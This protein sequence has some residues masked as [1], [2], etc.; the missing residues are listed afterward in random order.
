MPLRYQPRVVTSRDS[1]VVAIAA[2]GADLTMLGLA[3]G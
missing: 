3:A 1:L 2:T